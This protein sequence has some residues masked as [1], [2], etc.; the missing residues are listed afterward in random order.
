MRAR[1]YA[2]RWR[3]LG[4]KLERVMLAMMGKQ[5]AAVLPEPVWAH[6]MRS[7]P[8]RQMGMEYF[9]TGVGLS[10]LQRLILAFSPGPRSTCGVGARMGECSAGGRRI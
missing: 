8:C 7:R 2:L 9:W 1:G 10:Y 5:K 4:W 3:P 6:A